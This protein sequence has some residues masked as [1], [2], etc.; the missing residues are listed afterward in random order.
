MRQDIINRDI[1]SD[2]LAMGLLDCLQTG[3]RG[4]I[5]RLKFFIEFSISYTIY[6]Y[7]SQCYYEA[8]HIIIRNKNDDI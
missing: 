2:F 1:C 3:Y 8:M 6:D 5:F 4:L 7:R